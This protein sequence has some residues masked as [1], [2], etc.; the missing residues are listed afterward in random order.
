MIQS[1][2]QDQMFGQSPFNNWAGIF[3]LRLSFYLSNLL[4]FFLLIRGISI[5]SHSSIKVSSFTVI[6]KKSQKFINFPMLYF[7][8]YSF[9]LRDL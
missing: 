5:F 2:S 9:P 7:L 1:P 6:N 8:M 4:I 3:L